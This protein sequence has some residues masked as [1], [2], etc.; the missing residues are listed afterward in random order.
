[1]KGYSAFPKASRLEIHPQIGLCHIH[2]TC[3]RGSYPNAEMQSVYSTALA[4]WVMIRG[5]FKNI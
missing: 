1:M 4:D 5:I 3:S 2:D